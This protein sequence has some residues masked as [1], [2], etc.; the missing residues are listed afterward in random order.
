MNQ[1]K[2][3]VSAVVASGATLV[4]PVLAFAQNLST[5]AKSVTGI[6]QML[7]SWVSM[8][9][10]IMLSFGILAFFWG[11]VKYLWGE[12]A[13]GKGEG[14]KIMGYGILAVFVMAS[15]GGIVAL[16]QNTIGTGGQQNMNAPCVGSLCGR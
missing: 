4:L 11:L 7:Q 5:G 6:I 13:E 14:L 16:L 12:G 10:P 3:K 15:L 1:L 9:L 8:L 2:V